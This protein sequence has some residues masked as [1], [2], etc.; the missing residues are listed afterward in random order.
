M[1]GLISPS[2]TEKYVQLYLK[3]THECI[4]HTNEKLLKTRMPEECGND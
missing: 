2:A 3:A 4:H 1:S